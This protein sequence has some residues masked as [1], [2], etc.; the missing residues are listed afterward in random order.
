MLEIDNCP[1]GVII[2]DDDNTVNFFLGCS[3]IPKHMVYSNG[4]ESVHGFICVN[5]ELQLQ[6]KF[7]D[8]SLFCGLIQ[9]LELMTLYDCLQNIQRIA[10]YYSGVRFNIFTDSFNLYHYAQNIYNRH[11]K[12]KERDWFR[13]Q[14]IEGRDPLTKYFWKVHHVNIR[15]IPIKCQC[16]PKDLREF[17]KGMGFDFDLEFCKCI[18][19]ANA[20]VDQLINNEVDHPILQRFVDLDDD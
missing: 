7:I 19:K 1:W 16:F 17:L 5:K 11:L 9:D 18:I 10:P 2:P 6:A 14:F 20:L 15:L 13:R 8:H 12:R 3:F 4:L